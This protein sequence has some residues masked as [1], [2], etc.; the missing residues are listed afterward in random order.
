MKQ[1]KLAVATTVPSGRTVKPQTRQYRKGERIIR[2]GSVMQEWI[3]ISGG[4]ACVKAVAAANAKV[5]VAVLWFGDIVGWRSPIGHSV[6]EYDVYALA[7]VETVILP[8]GGW[9]ASHDP[10]ETAHLYTATA[11]RLNRQIAMRLAGNGPQRLVNVLATLGDAFNAGGRHLHHT[12]SLPVARTCLGQLAGLSR[13]QVWIYLTQL[14]KAG[15]IEP[16][17]TRVVLQNFSSWRAL[18]G[19]VER[20]G[21]ECTSTI[22]RAIETLSNVAGRVLRSRRVVV[23]V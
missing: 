13:Q 4:T 22:D 2:A 12:Q 14:A 18:R 1:K 15:W 10:V 20:R 21:P 5:A 16:S 9:G 3:A 23:E 8:G 7:D 19:E 17:H 6:A 11:S